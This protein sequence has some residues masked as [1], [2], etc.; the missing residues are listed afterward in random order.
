MEKPGTRSR[1]V[2]VSTYE[3][4]GTAILVYSVIV[5][6]G[7]DW[8]V[9]LTLAF[10]ICFMAYLTGAHF[11]P[12]QLFATFWLSKP[13]D[14]RQYLMLACFWGSQFIGGLF[15]VLM[16]YITFSGGN[17]RYPTQWVPVL[18]PNGLVQPDDV[19]TGCDLTGERYTSAFL[20]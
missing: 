1:F 4:L 6:G 2:M 14:W 8:S 16:S 11:N 13:K 10:L 17:K 9:A 18:C 19:A 7:N 12:S 3:F 20:Y 5:S 15:G